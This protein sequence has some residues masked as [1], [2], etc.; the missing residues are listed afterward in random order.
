MERV[1]K[2]RQL[3][4][5]GQLQA[6]VIDHVDGVEPGLTVLDSRLLLGQ[7]TIDVVALDARGALV[8]VAVGAVADEEMLLRAVEAYSWCLEYPEAIRR[9]YPTVH[10][11]P[12][13]PPRLVFVFERMP[14]AFHRKI[15]QLGFP[16]VDCVEFR[17]LDVDGAAAVY[18]DVLARLRRG[19]VAAVPTV[20]PVVP[21]AE[22]AGPSTSPGASTGRPTSVKLQK[23]LG[24]EKAPTAREPAQ[25]VTLR[26]RTPPRVEPKGIVGSPPPRLELAIA[27]RPVDT[28]SV[29]VDEPAL[30]AAEPETSMAAITAL[31]APATEVEDVEVETL[32]EPEV[33]MDPDDEVLPDAGHDLRDL[34]ESGLEDMPDTEVE[35][36]PSA[37]A[38]AAEKPEPLVLESS[39]PAPTMMLELEAGAL[40]VELEPV[41]TEAQAQHEPLAGEASAEPVAAEGP[42]EP[43][44]A[45]D[46]ARAEPEPVAAQAPVAERALEIAATVTPAVEPRTAPVPSPS[47]SVFARRAP[48]P[49]AVPDEPKVAFANVAKELLTPQATV[50]PVAPPEERASAF[51]AFSKPGILKRPRTIA[52][53][54][55]DPQPIAGTKLATNQT[56]SVPPPAPASETAPAS[57]PAHE[58]ADPALQGFEALQFP[59]DGVLTRQWMEFLNQMAAGK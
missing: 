4:E 36:E 55:S 38:V 46:A 12:A 7:A 9:L 28:P 53:P 43:A 27:Q 48:E 51:S 20:E 31:D 30:E 11:S 26:H 39:L 56:R 21:S 58:P 16:E 59:N 40:R 25:V 14:D 29:D 42:A 44:P 50:P 41:V 3:T 10:V 57:T 2:R 52:P 37:A 45:A 19:P 18:F 23:L 15:K 22:P 1:V 17:Y 24:G 47:T 8:L 5:P 32:S 34:E 35:T 54:P 33:A 13:Q 49:V 6:L